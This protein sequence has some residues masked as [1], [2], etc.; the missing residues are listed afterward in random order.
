MAEETKPSFETTLAELE[1]IVKRLESGDLPL[2]ESIAL[3]ERGMQ[4]SAQSRA[5]L[6]AAETRVELLTRKNNDR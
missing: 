4:L 5:Q 3:Y 1:G 2:E 6:E